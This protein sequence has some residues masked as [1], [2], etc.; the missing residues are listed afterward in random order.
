MRPERGNCYSRRQIAAMFGGDYVSYL[1][2]KDGVTVC[3][4]FKLSMNPGA[5]EE[6]VFGSGPKV[7]EAARV[8]SEQRQAIPVFLFRAPAKWEYVGIYRCA[9]LRTDAE[10]C[11]SADR[12]K[13]DPD[14]ELCGVLRFKRVG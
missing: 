14:D 1:P 3:G 10:T 6:V 8:V 12:G 9:E 7:V 4:C 5:P 2:S 11:R 13:R